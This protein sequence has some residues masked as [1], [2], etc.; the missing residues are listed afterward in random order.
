M[1]QP[2]QVGQ[3]ELGGAGYA[4][5]QKDAGQQVFLTQWEP[6]VRLLGRTTVRLSTEDLSTM[7]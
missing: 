3:W 4:R 1:K 7:A 2:Y 6:V 5:Q